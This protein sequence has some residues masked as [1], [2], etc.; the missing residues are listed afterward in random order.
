LEYFCK[1]ANE[2][3]KTGCGCV[4]FDIGLGPQIA[5]KVKTKSFLKSRGFVFF[6]YLNDQ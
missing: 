2:K 1:L 4:N 6:I 3:S 5:Q